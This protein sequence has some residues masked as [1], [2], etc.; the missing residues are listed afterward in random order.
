MKKKNLLIGLSMMAFAGAALASFGSTNIT[1]P[2]FTVNEATLKDG[3]EAFEK[4]EN[5]MEK[6]NY[7]EVVDNRYRNE[8]YIS[9]DLKPYIEKLDGFRDSILTDYESYSKTVYYKNHNTNRVTYE[10]AVMDFKTA[11]L[12]YYLDLYIEKDGKK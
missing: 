1:E 11:N 10:K 3:V 9:E 4:T 6:W 12:I 7:K 2:S 5:Q 8:E